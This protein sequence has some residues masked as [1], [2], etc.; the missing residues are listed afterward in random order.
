MVQD[1]TGWY[2]MVQD[3]MACAARKLW[4]KKTSF[5][6]NLLEHLLGLVPHVGVAVENIPSGDGP[7]L[8]C[9]RHAANAS[10]HP[11]FSWP[12]QRCILAVSCSLNMLQ[13][14]EARVSGAETPKNK[15]S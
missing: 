8:K 9:F 14:Q 13:L 6:Q 11:W 10:T 4:K 12:R 15:T 7:Y 1:G 3:G 5:A 2:R